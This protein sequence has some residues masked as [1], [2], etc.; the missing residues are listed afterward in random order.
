M[1]ALHQGHSTHGWAEPVKIELEPHQTRN[2]VQK[3][4]LKMPTT[5]LNDCYTEIAWQVC[6]FPDGAPQYT[7]TWP[8][9]E[10]GMCSTPPEVLSSARGQVLGPLLFQTSVQEDRTW[11]V[12]FMP[13]GHSGGLRSPGILQETMA[14]L[15]TG[16]HM[17]YGE[18]T[19]L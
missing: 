16:G 12:S 1:V 7:P 15:A 2:K 19:C 5:I 11:G 14:K 10:W 6:H 13:P 17:V 18:N 8:A 3:T 4:K 9:Q